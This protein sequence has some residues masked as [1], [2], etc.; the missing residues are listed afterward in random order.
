M[1]LASVSS[2]PFVRLLSLCQRAPFTADDAVRSAV[3]DVLRF[4]GYKPTGRGKPASEYLLRAATEGALGPINASVDACNAV[5]LH[6]G[7][8]I[9]VVD[10]D[11]SSPALRIEIAPAGT[12]Y[13]FNQAGQEMDL[14]GLVA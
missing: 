8:P 4:G 2:G 7:L 11:R 14:G 9:S 13:V 3:R 5:S 6:S 12:R 10:L 1:P